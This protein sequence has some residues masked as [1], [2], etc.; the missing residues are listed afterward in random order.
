MP[1]TMGL[2]PDLTTRVFD[3]GDVVAVV[4][5]FGFI[6]S[7]LL[8]QLLFREAHAVYHCRETRVVRHVSEPT[9]SEIPDAPQLQFAASG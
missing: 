5:V 3:V 9:Y 1:G 8:L 4:R 2:A 7:T 6:P